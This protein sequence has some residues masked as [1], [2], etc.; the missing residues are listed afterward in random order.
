MGI[1][2]SYLIPYVQDKVPLTEKLDQ[3]AA[4]IDLPI[5]KRPQLILGLFYGD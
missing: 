3:I 5:E 1:R 4:W 2:F